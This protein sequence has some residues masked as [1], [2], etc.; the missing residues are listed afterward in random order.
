MLHIIIVVFVLFTCFQVCVCVWW[1]LLSGL[2][3]LVCE[4]VGSFVWVIHEVKGCV[5]VWV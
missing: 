4:C 2:A 1:L 3:K 5:S